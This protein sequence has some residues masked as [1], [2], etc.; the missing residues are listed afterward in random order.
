MLAFLYGQTQWLMAVRA[1]AVAVMPDVSDS[2]RL[3]SQPASQANG[4]LQIK[5]VFTDPGGMVL[6]KETESQRR[7]QDQFEN[8][9]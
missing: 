5:L 9:E 3:I 1:L 4:V 2:L 7:K 6:G 8:K